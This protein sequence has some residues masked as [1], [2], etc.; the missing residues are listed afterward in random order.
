MLKIFVYLVTLVEICKCD[1]NQ[2]LLFDPRWKR[3]VSGPIS[4]NCNSNE[5]FLVDNVGGNQANLRCGPITIC[6]QSRVRYKF[7]IYL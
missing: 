6:D 2:L 5:V 4:Y 3:S 7:F 1:I